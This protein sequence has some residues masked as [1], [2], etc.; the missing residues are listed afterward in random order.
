MRR[1]W[2][3]MGSGNKKKWRLLV[4]FRR[5]E[6]TEK[7]KAK[8]RFSRFFFLKFIY[9]QDGRGER[10]SIHLSASAGLSPLTYWDLK[11]AKEKE[12]M[13]QA[14]S[15]RA[16]PSRVDSLCPFFFSFLKY[17]SRRINQL[18]DILWRAAARENVSC[19]IGVQDFLSCLEPA[20][21]APC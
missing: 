13:M 15:S 2:D 16:E 20:W 8:R 9:F 18:V 19:L 7:R 10:R 6:S 14:E 4:G 11:R 12:K 5:I 1:L 17:F 3:Q 21:N